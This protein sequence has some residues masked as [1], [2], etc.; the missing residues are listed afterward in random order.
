[1]S[2]L[3]CGI[4]CS[5]ASLNEFL[6]FVT[7]RLARLAEFIPEIFATIHRRHYLNL[8]IH[9][10][11]DFK[12]S[13]LILFWCFPGNVFIVLGFAYTLEHNCH[14]W[15]HC[16]ASIWIL[17]LPKSILQTHGTV[18][19]CYSLEP[20]PQETIFPCQAVSRL[21][22]ALWFAGT[23]Q[24]LLGALGSILH[25]EI[26]HRKVKL[27]YFKRQTVLGCDTLL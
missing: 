7:V 24:V 3:G 19:H 17:K 6:P 20:F 27:T 12:L 8:Q 10:W 13:W 15:G 14:P 9:V 1:M 21:F 16:P 5:W 26:S 22:F 23:L 4:K 2:W 25:T 18:F 11:K